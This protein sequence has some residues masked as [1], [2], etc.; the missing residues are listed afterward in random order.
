GVAWQPLAL[1]IMAR[2]G[3]SLMT[4]R[5]PLH[6]LHARLGARFGEAS[7]G[8]VPLGYG[9][10]AAEYRAVRERVGILDRSDAGVVEATGRDRA[11]FLHGM[12]SHDVKGLQPGQGRRAAFLDAHGKV[13]S[14]MVVHCLSDRLLLTMDRELVGPTLSALDRY[15]I[16]ER[17]EYEDVSAAHG[18]L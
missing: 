1:A 17:V 16:S 15:L 9:E 6:D 5:L 10:P 8:Q 4:T 11:T 14:L 2:S 18:C 3:F 12:L 13:V 7:G